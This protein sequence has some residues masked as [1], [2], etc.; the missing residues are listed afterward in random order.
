MSLKITNISTS[1][2]NFDKSATCNRRLGIQNP[3]NNT[4]HQTK[5]MVDDSLSVNERSAHLN[6]NGT[7]I[8]SI[9]KK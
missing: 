4:C 6:N 1:N 7:N 2:E 8:E 5:V 9:E 3:N